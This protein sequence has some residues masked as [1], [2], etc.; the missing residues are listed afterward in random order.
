M[1]KNIINKNENINLNLSCMKNKIIK[2]KKEKK[3]RNCHI[4]KQK[5]QVQVIENSTSRTKHVALVLSIKGMRNQVLDPQH[6]I[7]INMQQ[8]ILIYQT[9]TNI[10]INNHSV[11]W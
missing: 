8:N 7:T 5:N 6:N 1:T 10:K 11:N 2:K 4:W 3:K 9:T